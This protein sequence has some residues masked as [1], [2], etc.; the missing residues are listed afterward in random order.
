MYCCLARSAS[1]VFALSSDERRAARRRRPRDCPI[2]VFYEGSEGFSSDHRGLQL[3]NKIIVFLTAQVKCH[4]RIIPHSVDVN[5]ISKDLEVSMHHEDALFLFLLKCQLE[6]KIEISAP[7]AFPWNLLDFWMSRL[8][9]EGQRDVPQGHS[10]RHFPVVRLSC[11]ILKLFICYRLRRV[12][13]FHWMSG[14]FTE[15]PPRIF[16]QIMGIWVDYMEEISCACTPRCSKRANKS[17]MLHLCFA[18]TRQ[19]RDLKICHHS[20][21]CQHFLFR[22]V[23]LLADAMLRLYSLL[24]WWI[25][26]KC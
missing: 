14:S 11:L 4:A 17:N 18:E 19:R 16:K 3:E 1:W 21:A 7:L 10:D 15:I 22:N 9:S 23:L 2:T 26:T 24:M 6:F 13:G 5:V 8:D 25:S 20:L 12:G